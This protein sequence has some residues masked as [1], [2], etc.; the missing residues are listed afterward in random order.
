ML[1]NISFIKMKR[2]TY[3]LCVTLDLYSRKIIAH[4]TGT[5]YI[6]NLVTATFKKIFAEIKPITLK[7]YISLTTVKVYKIHL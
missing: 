7:Y 5:K 6:T 2:Q 1:F 4:K 3:Y